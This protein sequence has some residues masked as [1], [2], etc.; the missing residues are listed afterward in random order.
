MRQVLR[1]LRS[2]PSIDL[3]R[4]TKIG[5][6]HSLSWDGGIIYWYL[7]ALGVTIFTDTLTSELI[8]TLFDQV[9][10]ILRD[11]LRR[12]PLILL[13]WT[14]R[15]LVAVSCFIP[16]LQLQQ[17]SNKRWAILRHMINKNEK[18]LFADK[19][20]SGARPKPSTSSKTTMSL[21]QE[22]ITHTAV[23]KE[24]PQ[25]SKQTSP[26]F[27]HS[28]RLDPR[29]ES[30]KESIPSADNRQ[31]NILIDPQPESLYLVTLHTAVQICNK[32]SSYGCESLDIGPAT[33]R[34][35][36]DALHYNERSFSD[37]TVIEEVGK[38]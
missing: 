27:G 19:W 37:A 13:G 10:L 25:H 15:A 22:K 36:K 33:L 8:R 14:I 28:K 3:E 18:I 7:A 23:A 35:P 26:H 29:D 21:G 30:H 34:Q 17:T 2:K 12:S 38:H 11:H 6:R 9:L 5:W 32:S 20:I 1:A 31:I 24:T 16:A 4:F